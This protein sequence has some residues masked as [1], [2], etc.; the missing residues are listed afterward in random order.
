MTRNTCG[1]FY[2]PHTASFL[3]YTEDFFLPFWSVERTSRLENT[4]SFAV[5]AQVLLIAVAIAAIE[6]GYSGYHI[7]GSY[8]YGFR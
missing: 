1:T 6:N 8:G 7:Y 4:A 2:A 3:V 5:I